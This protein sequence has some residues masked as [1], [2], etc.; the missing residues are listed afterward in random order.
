MDHAVH[1]AAALEAADADEVV[2]ELLALSGRRRVALE[3]ALSRIRY[4]DPGED[5]TRAEALV[6][7]ALRRGDAI[8]YWRIDL[9]AT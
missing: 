9:T 6:R 2:A 7:A 1:V 3:D 4:L 5:A 8:D